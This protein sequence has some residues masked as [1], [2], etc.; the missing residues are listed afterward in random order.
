MTLL[1]ACK[2]RRA[3]SGMSKDVVVKHP[4]MFSPAPI[5]SMIPEGQKAEY[6]REHYWDTFDFADT[7]FIQQVDSSHMLTAFAVYAVG[8]VPDSLAYKYMPRLMRNASVSKRM[9][10]YFLGLAETVVY[11]PN[12]QL[13]ND[14]KYI[15]VLEDAVQSKWLDEYERMP[16]EYDLEIASQN[17]VGY[18]A[19]DFVYTLA[20]GETHRMHSIK[21]DYTLIFI[22][23]PG[24]P[25]CGDIKKQI[26]SSPLLQDLIARKELQVLVVYPDAVHEAWREHLLDYPSSWINAY[27]AE[28]RIDKERLY[29]LKAI[30]SLYLLDVQ[31]HVM[32]KDCTDVSYVEA[33]LSERYD[34]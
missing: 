15:P 28:Q 25:M 16:Y 34:K 14:E 11:D 30:P 2:G 18:L 1:V 5:P 29:D 7:M 20:S 24:C 32:A 12:S 8:H 17:R 26:I 27:D 4:A 19:N 23:N 10:N 33:L 9:D 3:E 21:A 31:K 6:M 22:S 13:R